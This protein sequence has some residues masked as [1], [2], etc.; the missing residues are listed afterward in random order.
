M[1]C[2]EKY[3]LLSFDDTVKEVIK[4]ASILEKYHLV[5]TFFLDIIRVGKELTTEDIKWLSEYHEVGSHGLNHLDLTK[6]GEQDT[7]YELS[8]SRKILSKMTQRG[9]SSLA[10]PYG[11]YNQRVVEM[12]GRVGYKCARIAMPYSV[13]ID[14]K[15]YELNTTLWA[16]PNPYRYYPHAIKGF[17]K[18]LHLFRLI[19]EPHLLKDWYRLALYALE[20]ALHIRRQIKFHIMFHPRFI[21]RRG[22]WNKMEEICNFISSNSHIF[23]IVTISQYVDTIGKRE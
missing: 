7:F 22:E 18:D 2:H 20:K 12:A 3:F 9:V 19:Y 16:D 1:E 14:R 13:C 5:G 4:V 23:N 15:F 10:Y 8:E 17:M 6:L 11:D 21:D